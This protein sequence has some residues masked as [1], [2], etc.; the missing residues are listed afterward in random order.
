MGLREPYAAWWCLGSSSSCLGALGMSTNI[1]PSK[2]APG[3]T[4]KLRTVPAEAAPPPRMLEAKDP[5]PWPLDPDHVWTLQGAAGRA[6]FR[7]RQS[8]SQTPV[9]PCASL[10]VQGVQDK[11]TPLCSAT[12]VHQIGH[13]GRSPWAGP[14]RVRAPHSG[15]WSPWGAR[16]LRPV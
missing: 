7:G 2:P 3:S 13:G 5:S 8:R 16:L 1:G 11:T 14:E 9:S 15:R 10:R 4:T 12:L 6:S